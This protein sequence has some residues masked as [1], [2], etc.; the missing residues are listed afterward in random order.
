VPRGRRADVVR[1]LIFWVVL[2]SVRSLNYHSTVERF[3]P[4]FLLGGRHLPDEQALEVYA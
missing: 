1:I 2:V 4:M 3:Y